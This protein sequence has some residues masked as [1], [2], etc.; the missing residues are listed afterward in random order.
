LA[1]A[2]VVWAFDLELFVAIPDTVELQ[3][4]EWGVLGYI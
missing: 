4:E 3:V 2:L 1:S